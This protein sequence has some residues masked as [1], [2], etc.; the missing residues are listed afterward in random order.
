MR[1]P[2]GTLDAG[3]SRTFKVNCL[4]DTS[5]D[6]QLEVGARGRGD[7][8]ASDA[9]VT[10]VETIA[11]L[12]LSV[13]DPKGPLP[14]GEDVPYEIK[15]QNRGSK[16]AVGVKLVMQ[17]SEGIE[18]KEA[19]G[20]KHQLTDGQVLF[21]P[22]EKINPGEEMT[23]KVTA[24]A[25][26]AGTHIFRAQLTCEESDSRE[27]A[28]GTTRFFGETIQPTATPVA[29]EA[30]ASALGSNDFQTQRK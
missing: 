9:C 27:V 22:I 1:W 6:L 20:L 14:T 11:D 17:F 19:S 30:K 21:S 3:Q 24:E 15:V 13:A 16:T 5:G 8:A 23:V 25:M 2:V 4:L 29:N 7:L 12:V 28:E 10:K 18:P 26:K